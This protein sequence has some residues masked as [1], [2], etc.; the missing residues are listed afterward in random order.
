MI[1]SMPSRVITDLAEQISDREPI[2]AAALH[3]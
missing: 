2:Y 1:T 3:P